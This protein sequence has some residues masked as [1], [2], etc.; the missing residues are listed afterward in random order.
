METILTK[1]ALPL[2]P[3]TAGFLLALVFACSDG[4]QSPTPTSPAVPPPVAP[5]PAGT[6]E[7]GPEVAYSAAPSP[8]PESGGGTSLEPGTPESAESGE[9]SAQ[10]G[11]TRMTTA[12][13]VRPA[14]SAGSGPE[15]PGNPGGGSGEEEEEEE[16]AGEGEEEEPKPRDPP[17]EQ[18]GPSI[19]AR[20][21]S[22]H[23]IFVSWSIDDVDGCDSDGFDVSGPG[24]NLSQ[25]TS[26]SGTATGLSD[27]P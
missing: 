17:C 6:T 19:S 25:T 18:L 9:S 7:P 11:D 4:G 26:T 27:A 3:R 5:A 10:P 15:P 22:S 14:P 20:A 8:A 2:R 23:S 12:N 16:E 1:P 13:A 24:L 21:T